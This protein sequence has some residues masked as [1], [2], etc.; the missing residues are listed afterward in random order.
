MAWERFYNLCD[1][2]ISCFIFED[3]QLWHGYTKNE[4]RQSFTFP[5]LHVFH[6]CQVLVRKN[7]NSKII[8]GMLNI[9]VLRK[10]INS[11]SGAFQNSNPNFHNLMIIYFSSRFIYSNWWQIYWKYLICVLGT[12][13][14]LLS[15][16]RLSA[17]LTPNCAPDGTKL[18]T[19][20]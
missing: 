4:I 19:P 14:T 1:V 13:F 20:L 8:Q 18:L 16:T 6:H 3:V 11:F 7:C 10:C 2:W 17:P 9:F 5:Q 15:P 12:R